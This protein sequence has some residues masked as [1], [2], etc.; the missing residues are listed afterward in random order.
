MTL[1]PDHQSSKFELVPPQT[2][3]LLAP[4]CLRYAALKQN[5]YLTLSGPGGGG[6]IRPP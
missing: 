5:F 6:G 4:T 2:P 1:I 3:T